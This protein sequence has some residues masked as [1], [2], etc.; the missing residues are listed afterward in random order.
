MLGRFGALTN[1]FCLTRERYDLVHRTLYEPYLISRTCPIV[2]TIHD[3]IPELFPHYIKNVRSV[4]QKRKRAVSTAD[5][6]ISVSEHTTRD[7]YKI[8]PDACDKVATIPLAS[9][10]HSYLPSDFDLHWRAGDS[11]VVL[12]VGE[13]GGYK[14]FDRCISVLACLRRLGFDL[15]MLC[16]GGGAFTAYERDLI[17]RSGLN[18]RVN[19]LVLTD[20]D[21]ALAMGKCCFLISL[22]EYEGFGLPIL[23]AV[24]C[25]TRVVHSGGGALRELDFGRCLLVDGRCDDYEIA[26]SIGN[27]LTDDNVVYDS[28]M[29]TND[30]QRYS[31][32]VVA[33]RTAALY[34]GLLK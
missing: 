14:R 18:G 7:L 30:R 29:L 33:S 17:F 3:L 15:R 19:Q 1:V 34:R 16:V 20:R 23:E 9:Q 13:R 31:W 27:W 11:S 28:E 21:L 25:G 32:D 22:S 5:A 26:I 10:L 12:F 6:I 4:L 24:L 8:F 2:I